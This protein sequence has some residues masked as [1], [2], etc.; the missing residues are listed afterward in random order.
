MNPFEA[1]N[2]LYANRDKTFVQRA[3]HPENYPKL[4]NP[5][6]SVSTHSMAADMDAQGNWFAYPTVIQAQP[7]NWLQRLP[8]IEAWGHAERTG[9]RIPFADAQ[10][11]IEFSKEYKKIWDKLKK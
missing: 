10:K 9:Q 11:A 6:G 1:L 3:L 4:Q 7:G 5:D 2:I 8:K